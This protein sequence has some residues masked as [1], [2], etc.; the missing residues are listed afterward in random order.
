MTP[1]AILQTLP[2]AAAA[3]AALL[4]LMG[5]ALASAQTR[6][7]INAEAVAAESFDRLALAPMNFGKPSRQYLRAREAAV[8]RLLLE[9]L[10]EHGFSVSPVASFAQRWQAAERHFGDYYNP[11]NDQLDATRLRQ[12][13]AAAI[14]AHAD[15]DA[16]FDAVVF[17]NLIER[18]VSLLGRGQRKG[19]WD[20]VARR[21]SVHGGSGVS[22]DFDWN[23]PMTG[24]SLEVIV[25]SRDLKLLFR[26]VGGL[27][28][29][30]MIS[31]RKS[32]YV[33]INRLLQN[34]RRLSEG[35]RIALHPLVPM[36]DYP[37]NDE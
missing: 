8:D 24:V 35:V 22:Q 12:V 13:A 3:V 1:F 17:T 2:A 5:P 15:A 9:R 11:S 30:E 32:R 33:R 36:P 25:V 23:Q 16:D 27:D 20:G 10:V 21:A 34:P 14:R 19:Q 18:P 4:A 7:E 28:W 37:D 31:A 29:A 6:Y 26:S